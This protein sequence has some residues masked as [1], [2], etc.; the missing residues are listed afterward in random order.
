VT[1]V[2]RS[3]LLRDGGVRT[4]SESY[5]CRTVWRRLA[6]AG[7]IPA[8]STTTPAPTTLGRSFFSSCRAEGR[9]VARVGAEGCG[10]RWVAMVPGGGHLSFSPGVSSLRW[11]DGEMGR[12]PQGRRRWPLKINRLCA[13]CSYELDCGIAYRSVCRR[14]TDMQSL[15]GYRR[16][17]KMQQSKRSLRAPN[18]IASLTRRLF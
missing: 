10:L 1:G 18:R 6:D 7:S 13:D 4:K 16:R 5:A 8:G 14:G 11:G 3:V 9:V 12:S 15:I 2:V 17:G